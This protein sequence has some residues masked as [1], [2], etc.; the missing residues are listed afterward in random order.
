MLKFEIDGKWF[1]FNQREE[2]LLP[3]EKSSPGVPVSID[4]VA[5]QW[6]KSATYDD[7]ARKIEEVTGTQFI[8]TLPNNEL[9]FVSVYGF[10]YIYSTFDHQFYNF[11]SGCSPLDFQHIELSA[12]YED[13]KKHW[14]KDEMNKLLKEVFS[15]LRECQK[16]MLNNNI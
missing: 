4:F 1:L 14:G 5:R 8:P 16:S 9:Y 6:M 2:W 3:G 7:V 15:N 11:T 10:P 12:C 13:M